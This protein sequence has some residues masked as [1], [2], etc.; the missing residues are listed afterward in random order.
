MSGSVRGAMEQSIVPTRRELNKL[1]WNIANG[2]NM[3]GVHYFTDSI[4]S[5]LL[6]EAITLGILREQ[7]NA[8]DPR[9][10]VT[11]RVPLFV[12]RTLPEALL[13]PKRGIQPGEPVK[14]VLI[15]KMGI[16]HNV[17]TLASASKVG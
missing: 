16:L 4:E 11:M 10:E 3:A 1:A 13:D 5:L 9:E 2:R 8:Y 7:M 17:E 15:D 12:E 14:E 6:G